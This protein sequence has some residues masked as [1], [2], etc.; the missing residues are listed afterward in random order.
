[1][2]QQQNDEADA[3]DAAGV[4]REYLGGC[5][6]LQVATFDLEAA[7]GFAHVWF[8]VDERF[9]FFF[10]SNISRNH[11][12]HIRR[13]GTVAFGT[14]GIALDGLGQKVRGITGHGGAT[15]LADQ[16]L[17]EG[18]ETYSSRWS[19]ARELFPVESMLDG[20]SPMRVYRI[21]PQE[22]VLWDE[23]TFPDMPRQIVV[24]R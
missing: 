12:Q 3:L 11:S 20:T 17:R 22:L 16:E 6:L 2:S 19:K 8:A 15:E 4:A 1:M 13:T 10:A 18:F 7:P 24:S 14:V 21:E 9:N 5:K 23:V